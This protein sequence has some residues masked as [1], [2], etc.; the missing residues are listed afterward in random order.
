[1][2]MRD[3][4]QTITDFRMTGRERG[5]LVKMWAPREREMNLPRDDIDTYQS[6][7]MEA[8]EMPITNLEQASMDGR[9]DSETVRAGTCEAGFRNVR[10]Y[11]TMSA[12]EKKCWKDTYE[13]KNAQR[14]K[15]IP[16]DDDL[17]GAKSG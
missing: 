14:E 15:K 12:D 1:M 9:L 13:F 8:A 4:P 3:S 16:A 5:W 17:K 11:V 10:D 7:G 6:I 2:D